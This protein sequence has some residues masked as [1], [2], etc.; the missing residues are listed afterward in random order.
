MIR[1]PPRSTQSRSSAASDGDKRQVLEEIDPGLI[2]VF[3]N[4]LDTKMRELEYEDSYYLEVK[5][6]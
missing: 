5:D 4:K 3:I 1:R 6:E 2:N